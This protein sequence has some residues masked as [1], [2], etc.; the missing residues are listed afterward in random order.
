LFHR[1]EKPRH[2][3][4]STRSQ[5][6][7]RRPI[8]LL[9]VLISHSTRLHSPVPMHTRQADEVPSH[10]RPQE[11]TSS[12]QRAFKAAIITRRKPT[13]QWTARHH[14]APLMRTLLRITR[15]PL[16]RQRPRG[17]IRWHSP[18]SFLATLRNHRNQRQ[19]PYP[20]RSSLRA[21]RTLLM[22]TPSHPILHRESHSPKRRRHQNTTRLQ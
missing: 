6:R 3:T 5:R 14:K 9:P 4:A 16:K 22:V 12:L 11:I 10:S 18:A 8:A 1:L 17:Q 2:I 13:G 15:R 7:L 19:S 20:L 21:H